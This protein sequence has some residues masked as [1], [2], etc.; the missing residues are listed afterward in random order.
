MNPL[1]KHY[2][3]TD[4]SP[5]AVT[6]K[7]DTTPPLGGVCVIMSVGSRR[8]E[9]GDTIY[10]KTRK[11]GY[12]PRRYWPL[13]ADMPLLRHWP[14]RDQPFDHGRSE[15]IAFIMARCDVALNTAIR[16]FDSAR[17]KGVIRFD[18]E[19][20]LWCGTKGGRP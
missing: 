8:R 18:H 20:Q 7:T 10:P 13:V 4:I 3:S 5:A 11:P 2:F 12:A 14:D 9:T 19:T 6:D 1:T 15:V 16:I 17:R